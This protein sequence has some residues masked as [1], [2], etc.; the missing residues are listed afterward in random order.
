MKKIIKIVSVL[1]IVGSMIVQSTLYSMAEEYEYDDL[2]RV[3]KVIY[4]D[5]SYIEYEYDKNGNLLGMNVVDVSNNGQE[6]EEDNQEDDKPSEGE[7]DEGENNIPQQPEDD[8]PTIEDEQ[9]SVDKIIQDAVTQII[10]EAV[11]FAN[12]L[13]KWL[14]SWFR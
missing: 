14:K 11:T 8:A 1:A 13:I 3:T 2:N 10:N 4:E 9:E 12:K 7:S 6:N 5:G